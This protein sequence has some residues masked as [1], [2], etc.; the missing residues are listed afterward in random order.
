MCVFVCLVVF[1]ISSTSLDPLEEFSAL[2]VKQN[3][4]EKHKY[5]KWLLPHLYCFHLLLHDAGGSTGEY[6]K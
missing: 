2:Y 4:S 1:V 6:K 3:E 5:P